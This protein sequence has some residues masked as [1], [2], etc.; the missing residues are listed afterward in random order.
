MFTHAHFPRDKFRSAVLDE[1]FIFGDYYWIYISLTGSYDL[2]YNGDSSFDL[3]QPGKETYWICE[4]GT[5]ET[6]GLIR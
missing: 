2:S 5:R 1:K 3:V 4:I 6:R